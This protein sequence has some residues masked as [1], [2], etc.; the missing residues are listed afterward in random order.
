MHSH[1]NHTHHITSLLTPLLASC[2][3]RN[4]AAGEGA[5]VVV[6]SAQ[7]ESELVDLDDEERSTFLEEL[8]VERG[9]TGLEKLIR[10]A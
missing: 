5:K 1:D 8:G 2:Q 6:V 7:V 10:E 4:L 3:V 9:E